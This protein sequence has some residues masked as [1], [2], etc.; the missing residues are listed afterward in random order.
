MARRC[1]HSVR[2]DVNPGM[3]TALDRGWTGLRFACLTVVSALFA[4]PT[5]VAAQTTTYTFT[6]DLYSLTQPPYAAGQRLS[7]SFTVAAPLP[8]FRALGDLTPALVAMS[9][10]DGVAGRSLADSFVC[11]FDVATDGA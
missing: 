6:G 8:A 10:H 2:N 3:Q 1:P 7:G 9:F 5:G 4:F 11:A